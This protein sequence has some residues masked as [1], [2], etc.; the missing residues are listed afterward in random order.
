MHRGRNRMRVSSVAVP[1]R[2][3]EHWENYSCCD[4]AK[5]S[6][7]KPARGFV[8]G[9]YVSPFITARYLPFRHSAQKSPH[10]TQPLMHLWV[11]S[12]WNVSIDL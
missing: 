4:Q 10:N 7:A 6:L 3:G 12:P 5:S 2:P 11:E 1:V 9:A 8:I